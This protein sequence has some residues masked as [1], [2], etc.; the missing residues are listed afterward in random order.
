MTT[1]VKVIISYIMIAIVIVGLVAFANNRNEKLKATEAR[2]AQNIVALSD[3]VTQYENKNGELVSTKAIMQM[4][5]DQL[6]IANDS[7]AQWVKD[8]PSSVISVT[9]VV[10]KIQYDT[11]ISN[12]GIIVNDSGRIGITFN[13]NQD[14]I[15]FNSSTKFSVNRP[16]E[17][18]NTSLIV[19]N[20]AIDAGITTAIVEDSEGIKRIEVVSD[21]P[22]LAFTSIEGNIIPEDKIG[23]FD[24]F[25]LGIAIGPTANYDFIDKDF[26]IGIGITAG[27]VYKKIK[28]K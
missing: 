11:I 16:V 5:M 21:N 19:T 6:E 15:S 14:Q 18:S 3:T 25:G 12:E 17:L 1:Q 26:S 2:V 24:K 4:T 13:Y 28:R 9:K 8:N 7:L 23:F 22:H 20:L 27:L 10:T